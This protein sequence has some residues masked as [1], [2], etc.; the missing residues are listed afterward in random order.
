MNKIFLSYA[1]SDYPYAHKLVEHLKQHGVSGW[2]D[3]ADISSGGAVASKVRSAIQDSHAMVVLVSPESLRSNWVNFEVGAGMALDIP[4]IPIVVQG[5]GV[6]NDLPE[7]LRGMRHLD[8]RNR[9]VIEVA[10]ELEETIR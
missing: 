1:R 2:M 6:E 7:Q 9:P 5:E 8:A 10:K 4:I 3:S